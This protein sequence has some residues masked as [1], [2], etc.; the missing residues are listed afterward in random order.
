M[1]DEAFSAR[2][3]LV[4]IYGSLPVSEAPK[5]P[6]YVALCTEHLTDQAFQ[7]DRQIVE[8]AKVRI[9]GLLDGQPSA[10]AQIRAAIKE[11]L[12]HRHEEHL[13]LYHELIVHGYRRLWSLPQQQYFDRAYEHVQY[14]FD[15]FLSFTTRFEGVEGDNPINTNFQHFIRREL[16]DTVY[17]SADRKR[18]NLLAT[19]LHRLLS[20]PQQKGFFFRHM[21]GDNT[22]V[23]DKLAEGCRKSMVFVQLIQNAIFVEPKE[24][25]NYCFFEYEAATAAHKT[26]P[27]LQ[28]RIVFIFAED[29][30]DLVDE[31]LVPNRFTNWHDHVSRKDVPQ[32]RRIPLY[33]EKEVEAL[34][35]QIVSKVQPKV[36]RAWKRL[37][38]SVPV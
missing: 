36:R 7:T 1:P 13:D 22:I 27:D 33:D 34:R 17:D 25:K 31:T 28:D 20:S 12:H 29:S 6:A 4:R 35:S 38:D 18:T 10:V 30:G 16:T 19:V 2:A 15:F 14:E 32:L 23:E 37:L 8:D 9:E 26:A 3:Q 5:T 21:Q 11:L 24:R